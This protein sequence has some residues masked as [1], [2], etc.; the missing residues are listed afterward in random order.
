MTLSMVATPF[1][2]MRSEN[3]EKVPHSVASLGY[4]K[5]STSMEEFLGEYFLCSFG[6]GSG[7][8]PRV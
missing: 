8:M 1:S 6:S 7:I 4:S 2:N 3:V 5:L